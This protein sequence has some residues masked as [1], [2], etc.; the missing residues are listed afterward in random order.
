MQRP[1]KIEQAS[2]RECGA[3]EPRSRGRRTPPSHT[4]FSTTSEMEGAGS[5]GCNEAQDSCRQ[6]AL[7]CSAGEMFHDLGQYPSGRGS[8]PGRSSQRRR[9]SKGVSSD[10]VPS[11]SSP[12]TEVRTRRQLDHRR[13]GTSRFKRSALRERR[14]GG[15]GQSPKCGG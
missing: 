5:G 11:W 1:F 12:N 3:S 2:T 14:R 6:E 7:R 9:T 13:R 4:M 15:A 10:W 8:I